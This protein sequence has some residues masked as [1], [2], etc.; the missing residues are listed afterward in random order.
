MRKIPRGPLAAAVLA[1]TGTLTAT[2]ATAA[3]ARPASSPELTLPRPTGPHPVGHT[4]L[5]LVDRARTDPWVPASGPRR[6]LI[7]MWYPARHAGGPAVPYMTARESELLLAGLHVAGVPGNRLASVRTGA[8]ENAAPYGRRHTLPLVLLSPGFTLPRA[9]LT[10]LSEDLASRGYVVATVDH[11]YE[12]FGTTFPDGHTTT[13]VPCAGEPT[14]ALARK[15]VRGRT[16]DASFVL[17]R[18]TGA[19]PAWRGGMLIDRS[20]IGMTGHSIGGDAT[21]AAMVADRRIRAG[22]NLDGTIHTDLPRRGLSR[23]FLLIGTAA[24]HTPGSADDTSWK[25]NWPRL[26]GWKR[27]ITVAGTQHSSF[28][29]LHPLADR[30]GVDF[31]ATIHGDRATEITRAYTGA[32]FDRTLRA[33]HRPL[34]DGPARRFPEVAFWK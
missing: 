10:S 26:T 5:H 14:D 24:T 9:T 3:P 32:F 4:M 20:R 25:R 18:L 33:R 34:L 11:T 7:S 12:T 6:L 16:A 23:P 28:T 2:A 22:V 19:H 1:F 13:C 8:Y 15:V 17:D 27:W 30:L 21:A 29:D 31:G